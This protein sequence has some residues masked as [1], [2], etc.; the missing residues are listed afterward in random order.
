MSFY[1]LLLAAILIMGIAPQNLVGSIVHCHESH[2]DR[3]ITQ[4][5]MDVQDQEI[6]STNNTADNNKKSQDCGSTDCPRSHSHCSHSTFIFY[7]LNGHHNQLASYYVQA[8]LYDIDDGKVAN[9][10][11]TPFRPPLA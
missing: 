7:K 11:T 2:V 6:D 4:S 10:T 1:K 9:F 5:V 3:S 8:S